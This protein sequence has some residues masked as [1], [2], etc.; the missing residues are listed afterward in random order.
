KGLAWTSGRSFYRQQEVLH[1]SMPQDDDQHLPPMINIQQYYVEEFLV[2]ALEKHAGLVDIRWSSRLIGLEQ[3]S[4]SVVVEVEHE[5]RR[6]TREG[7]WLAACDGGRSTVRDALGLSLRGTAYEGA[8]VIADI[9]LETNLPTE[10]LA[11]FDPPSN[12]GET[13]LMHRQPD[14]IWRID[15]QIGKDEDP[16]KAVLPENVL[17]RIQAHLEMID[18]TGKW[19]PLWISLYRANA[20]ALEHFRHER[21]FF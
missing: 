9:E 10:R 19:A 15:Y 3:R 17:P 21:V 7:E 13:I 16:E 2:R 5:G 8:Y 1:F 18:E 14:N 12:P 4:G 20:L 6:H 11:W